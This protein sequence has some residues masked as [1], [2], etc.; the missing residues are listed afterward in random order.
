MI[1]YNSDICDSN[2]KPTITALQAGDIL[3]Y[4]IE[5]TIA[6]ARDGETLY[7]EGGASKKLLPSPTGRNIL[8]VSIIADIV[9]LVAVS[10]SDT[11]SGSWRFLLKESTSETTH[12]K[13]FRDRNK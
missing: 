11:Q 4:S 5:E 13:N 9:G 7:W 3:V 1:I 10:I 2:N 8:L 6:V 12:L